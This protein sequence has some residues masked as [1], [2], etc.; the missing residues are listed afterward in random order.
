MDMDNAPSRGHVP[1]IGE[2]EECGGVPPREFGRSRVGSPMG[3][4]IA[5]FVESG[6][7]CARHDFGNRRGAA[8]FCARARAAAK[9]RGGDVAVSQR[10]S[11]V[12]LA[13]REGA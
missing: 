1:A 4:L 10:G 8:E 6:M 5:A 11:A 7:A 9:A 13:R 3:D 12:Y 2:F